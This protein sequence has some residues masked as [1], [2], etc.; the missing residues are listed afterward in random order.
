MHWLR[1]TRKGWE[2]APWQKAADPVL[3]W[4]LRQEVRAEMQVVIAWE[5][6]H[7]ILEHLYRLL[8]DLDTHIHTWRM[9]GWP[10][11]CIPSP[12]MQTVSW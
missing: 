4:L 3:A 6:A 8:W 1:R 5:M 12:G 11:S 2:G 10:M 7:R 9:T